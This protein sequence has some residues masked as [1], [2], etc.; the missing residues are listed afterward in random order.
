MILI[1]TNRILA[2]LDPDPP[3]RRQVQ[4]EFVP[5]SNM[6]IG[7]IT[8]V[9]MESTHFLPKRHQRAALRLLLS[10][11][12][13]QFIPVDRLV[14]SGAVLDWMMN[15]ADQKPDFADACLVLLTSVRSRMK[16]WTNDSEF[17]T[18]WRRPDGSRVPLAV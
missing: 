3:S 15:Y 17:T 4:T 12:D 13:V 10:R 6:P 9:L 11:L 16:I 2:F 1:D 8:P 18:I 5:I 7:I 14:E